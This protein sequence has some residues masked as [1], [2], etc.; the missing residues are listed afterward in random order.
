[1]LIVDYKT[2]RP[3]PAVLAD[4][5]PAYLLQLALYRALLRPL[6]PG[7][8]IAAV[9]LFTEQPRLIALPDSALDDAL[10]R[11]TRA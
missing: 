1:M 8:K 9:L 11:L 10:A 4:V 6:Y 7:R 3:A 2:N 5:P